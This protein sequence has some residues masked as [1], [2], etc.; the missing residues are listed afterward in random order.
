MDLKRF[1]ARI[2][3]MATPLWSRSLPALVA[4]G[5]L[6]SLVVLTAEPAGGAVGVEKVSRVA[7]AP[8][9]P[10]ELTL[11]CGFCFPPCKG[12][13]GHRN[14]PCMLGTKAQPPE[15]FPVSLVPVEKAPKLH[16]CGPNAVCP[17]TPQGAPR[18][19][20]FTYLGEAT[21]PAGADPSEPHYV[22]RYLFDFEIPRLRP[23]I[24][25]YVIFCDVCAPGKDG[26]LIANPSAR[27][28]RLRVLSPGPR[29][30]EPAAFRDGHAVPGR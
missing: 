10:V 30:S 12:A 24:Y 21:P 2:S 3:C 5:L 14:V 1:L 16:R 22:P 8:G 19:A 7:G 4:A 18:R 15:A 28:W 27:A 26:S 9:D 13:P 23:G 17:P 6:A 25:T 20:P 29:G 11:G